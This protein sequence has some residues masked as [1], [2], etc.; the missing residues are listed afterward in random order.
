MNQNN[1]KHSWWYFITLGGELASHYFNLIVV[2]A[3][4]V[5]GVG[6]FVYG[7]IFSFLVHFFVG[8]Y[9]WLI[10]KKVFYAGLAK[11]FWMSGMTFEF[12]NVDGDLVP[13]PAY[14]ILRQVYSDPDLQISMAKVG[15][16]CFISMVIGAVVVVISALALKK[17]GIHLITDKF[18]RGRKLV[19][20]EKLIEMITNP[21]EP[22]IEG[23]SHIKIEGIPIPK[24]VINTNFLF[25]GDSGSGKS[26]FMF[27]I[28]KQNM[29]AGYKQLCY[30]A[31][32]GYVEAF[33][34]PG[35]DFI[36]C[37]VDA[38][39]ARWS[40]YSELRDKT[41]YGLLA[42][43][44]VP[45]EKDSNNSIFTDAARKTMED[46]IK[47]GH[48]RSGTMSDI[49]K[50]IERSTVQDFAE[51]FTKYDLPS[52]GTFNPENVKTGDSVKFTLSNQEAIQLFSFFDRKA[53]EEVFSIRDWVERDD[54]STLFIVNSS[55]YEHVVKPYIP[56]WIELALLQV[57]MM[58][59]Q[60]E[61]RIFFWADELASLGELQSL[62]KIL[63][64]ARKYGIST[65]VGIQNF[66]QLDELYSEHQTLTF[67][68]NLQTKMLMRTSEKDS[69]KRI[70]GQIGEADLLKKTEGNSYGADSSKDSGSV[71]SQNK[72]DEELVKS[73]ELSD[74][75]NLTGF[76]KISGAFPV[77]K[78][79]ATY[80]SWEKKNPT[81]IK[82]EGLSI[83]PEDLV[84]IPAQVEQVLNRVATVTPTEA[85]DTEAIDKETGEITTQVVEE[86]SM[87][88]T[89]N[90]PK[91][92]D[93]QPEAAKT[94]SEI[95]WE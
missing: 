31:T 1:H 46:I 68:S 36:L 69:A 65:F 8:K 45:K 23:L 71:N 55:A 12:P 16:L 91:N 4:R 33:Y 70:V 28:F 7:I 38:R 29:D 75:K 17:Y 78:V 58:G 21:E 50:I 74:L 10:A 30:D 51:L 35:K 40:I 67:I 26:Q 95:P 41:D 27:P 48:M 62:N 92:D 56:A 44:F 85:I 15:S 89:A 5:L 63:T 19:S 77:T 83:T 64:E 34:R 9:D 25:T 59:A 81:F 14:S 53:G 61:T 39:C 2:N 93:E 60:S 54:D 76:L 57:M 20:K 52:Q 82:R 79:T 49:Q 87:F 72:D 32:G 3:L 37:P 88:P 6:L 86:P 24:D 73:N 94:K 90:K 11:Y 47:V 22:L 80:Q 66:A 43:L 13:T 84:D 18:I 42:K